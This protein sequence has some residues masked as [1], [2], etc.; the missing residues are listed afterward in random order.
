[1]DVDNRSDAQVS[2]QSDGNGLDADLIMMTTGNIRTNQIKDF[3]NGVLVIVSPKLSCIVLDKYPIDSPAQ[4]L[5]NIINNTFGDLSPLSIAL[6][7]SLCLL[8]F[9]TLTTGNYSNIP[10]IF[11]Y[12]IL[13]YM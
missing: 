2:N 7:S 8:F 6:P 11:I 10:T 13:I 9:P 4:I 3:N 12:Y 5:V 1:M